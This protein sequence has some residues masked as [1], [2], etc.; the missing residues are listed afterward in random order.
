MIYCL[1]N[2][3]KFGQRAYTRFKFPSNISRISRYQ[4][5]KINASD[6]SRRSAFR[7]IAMIS[8][9]QY[10]LV[11]FSIPALRLLEHSVT[12]HTVEKSGW[13]TD[14]SHVIACTGS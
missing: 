14:T 12:V 6:L 3:L 13:S 11:R 1:Y 7:G 8:F 10:E 4:S 2:M 5:T 9:I